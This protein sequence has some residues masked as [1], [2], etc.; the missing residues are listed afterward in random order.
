MFEHLRNEEGDPILYE[1]RYPSRQRPEVLGMDLEDFHEYLIAAGGLTQY[2]GMEDLSSSSDGLLYVDPKALQ[3]YVQ[4][5]L[6]ARDDKAIL[7]FFSPANPLFVEYVKFDLIR[8]ILG[9]LH[10]NGRHDLLLKVC[11]QLVGIKLDFLTV[12]GFVSFYA[13]ALNAQER[14]DESVHLLGK[15]DEASVKPKFPNDVHCVKNLVYALWFLNRNREATE[16]VEAAIARGLPRNQFIH[17]GFKTSAA[18]PRANHRR[19]L[20]HQI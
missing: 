16:L 3:G 10:K 6:Y 14:F 7:E 2:D 5:L 11:E 17:I 1:P 15:E 20:E 13:R 19:R 4:N 9:M 8:G 18:G 12:P